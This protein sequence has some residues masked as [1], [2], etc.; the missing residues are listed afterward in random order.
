M[1]VD[2]N[3]CLKPYGAEKPSHHPL[4]HSRSYPFE[5]DLGQQMNPL[6]GFRRL[7]QAVAGNLEE[8]SLRTTIHYKR[9]MR[10]AHMTHLDRKKNDSSREGQ[11]LNL[12]LQFFSSKFLFAEGMKE[13]N[14]P[15]DCSVGHVNLSAAQRGWPSQNPSGLQAGPLA[16]I[17]SQTISVQLMEAPNAI[18]A[19]KLQQMVRRVPWKAAAP[20]TFP[21]K[22]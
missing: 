14:S 22:N 1:T 13:N 21:Q 5:P 11:I 18:L 12:K 6:S 3:S 15:T 9:F 8:C 4:P 10:M 2:G 17:S 19:C 20:P 16:E 7:F